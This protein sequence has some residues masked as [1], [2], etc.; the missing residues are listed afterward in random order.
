LV[1]HL[2]E[3]ESERRKKG[4]K[5]D[6]AESASKPLEDGCRCHHLTNS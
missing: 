1:D 5:G 3:G 2:S 4:V 6:G